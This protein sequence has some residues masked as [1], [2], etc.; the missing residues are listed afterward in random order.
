MSLTT[1][2]LA[3][4]TWV[5]RG[6]LLLVKALQSQVH[7]VLC[8]WV[9]SLRLVCCESAL[10]VSWGVCNGCFNPTSSLR[11]YA[12]PC[13][14]FLHPP[15]CFLWNLCQ[16]SPLLATDDST[17][18]SP[19]STLGANFIS[20]MTTLP[21]MGLDRPATC[22]TGAVGGQGWVGAHVLAYPMS[23]SFPQPASGG[24]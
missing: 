3:R 11:S 13:S 19:F 20:E 24:R 23:P 17:C 21:G 15:P 18:G 9:Y 14:G 22:G 1:M 4:G 8:Q 12:V 7:F 5:H 6:M 10:S 16:K 2:N